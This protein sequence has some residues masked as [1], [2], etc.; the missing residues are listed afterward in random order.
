MNFQ[1]T[2]AVI[3]VDTV[4]ISRLEA[5]LMP[6]IVLSSFI[7]VKFAQAMTKGSGGRKSSLRRVCMYKTRDV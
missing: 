4:P 1:F 6:A 3:K 2:S 5:G 7:A